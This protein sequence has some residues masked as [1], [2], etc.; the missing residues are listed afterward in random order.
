MKFKKVGIRYGGK[1]RNPKLSLLISITITIVFSFTM[2]FL[3]AVKLQYLFGAFMLF[4]GIASIYAFL[5]TMHG[6]VETDTEG[7]QWLY[8]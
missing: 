7:K 1:K 8:F 3:L 5:M 2:C 4:M 6:V